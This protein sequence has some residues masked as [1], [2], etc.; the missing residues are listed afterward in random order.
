[1]R[2][3][4]P[5]VGE[6]VAGAGGALLLIS[7]FLPWFRA[8]GT[9]RGTADEVAF[10]AFA[11]LDL[12]LV[13]LALAGLGLLLAE[14]VTPTPAIP[15]AWA[16]LT[17]L[18]GLVGTLWVLVTVLSPPAAG[19]EPLFALL[20]LVAAAGVTVGAFLSMRDEGFGVRPKPG[21]GATLSRTA[22]STG[23][24]PLA[25]PHTPRDRR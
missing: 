24:E 8:T 11:V 6:I 12:L 19:L 16:A 5:R 15:V 1:M 9:G 25:V 17:G 21:L 14:M 23:P 3:K 18:L 13:A 4:P 20:G 7:L 22:D 10:E 2:L